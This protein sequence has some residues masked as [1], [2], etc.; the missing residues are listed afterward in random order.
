V[1]FENAGHGAAYRVATE[2]YQKEI[3][4]FLSSAGL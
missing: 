4:S 3:L 1:V 2:A